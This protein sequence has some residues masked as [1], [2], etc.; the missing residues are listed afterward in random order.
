VTASV[1]LMSRSAGPSRTSVVLAQS[2]TSL[3]C[4]PAGTTGC[5]HSS[6]IVLLYLHTQVQPMMQIQLAL[7][8]HGFCTEGPGFALT[9][10]S[11][12]LDSPASCSLCCV[13][14]TTLLLVIMSYMDGPAQGCQQLRGALRPAWLMQT[15]CSISQARQ[16]AATATSNT[17]THV[18]DT[19]SCPD[20]AGSV[21]SIMHLTAVPCST[22]GVYVAA[23]HPCINAE[24]YCSV[25]DRICELLTTCG[26]T[27][28]GSP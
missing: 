5:W 11:S 13:S 1:C 25:G 24:Q 15:T 3:L 23:A 10:M 22:L 8:K 26:T 18:A 17:M 21:P 2:V 4:Q 27:D 6:N 7:F 14:F 9:P 19:M 28:K 20:V 12:G 16:K